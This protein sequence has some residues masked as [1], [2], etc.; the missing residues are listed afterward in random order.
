MYALKVSHFFLSG[1]NDND[2]NFSGNND[3]NGW[4]STT[5]PPTNNEADVP[6]F[7]ADD[8]ALYV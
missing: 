6:F 1:N 3:A 7:S 4:T 2:G 8:V 5:R